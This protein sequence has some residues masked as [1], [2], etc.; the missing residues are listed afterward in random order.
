MGGHYKRSLASAIQIGLGNC[1]GIIASNIFLKAEAP[2]YPTG[3]G[4]SLALMG[5]TG[6]TS[7]IMFIGLK[8]EN[9]IRDRG[10]RDYRLT[11]GEDLGNMGDDHPHFRFTT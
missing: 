5:L 2:Y 3:F 1:G 11:N 4:T 9:R 7:T 10:G 6:I 8:W